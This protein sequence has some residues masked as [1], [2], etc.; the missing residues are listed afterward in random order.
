ML[1]RILT[2]VEKEGF[3]RKI[4]DDLESRHL[5][6]YGKHAKAEKANCILKVVNYIIENISEEIL[7]ED[8]EGVSGKTKF[9]ICRIFN[10]FYGITPIKWMWKIRLALAKEYIDLAP[11]WSL[12]DISCA[13]GF[14][15]LPH[16]SRSFSLAY[17]Q[18]P[19]KFKK[20]ARTKIKSD[21]KGERAE[22]DII[23]GTNRD[24][25]SKNV[26]INNLHLI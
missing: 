8:L 23:F 5:A 22:F 19:M 15:S 3:T 13:C 10:H 6:I 2:D 7:L 12:T 25:F 21:F 1:E 24:N 4:M 9:D 11:E 14:S 18:T 17:K 20:D 26:L 16:F